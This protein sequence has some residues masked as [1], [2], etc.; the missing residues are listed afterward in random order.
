MYFMAPYVDFADNSRDDAVTDDDD[1]VLFLEYK[2]F[3]EDN[4][5]PLG[6]RSTSVQHKSEK[7]FVGKKSLTAT[8]S[9]SADE[10]HKMSSARGSTVPRQPDRTINEF[11]KE[12]TSAL[13]EL[14]HET[15]MRVY[16]DILD[17]FEKAKQLNQ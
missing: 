17:V 13:M 16:G 5:K 12:I 10:S 1:E 3:V 11:K 7:P 14:D 8:H 9:C 2:V 6:D 4:K 15:R